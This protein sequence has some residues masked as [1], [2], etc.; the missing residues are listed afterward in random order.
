M[1]G[2]SPEVS[3]QRRAGRVEKCVRMVRSR[4]VA[5]IAANRYTAW[6][7]SSFARLFDPL[8]LAIL[9]TLGALLV[10]KRRRLSIRLLI[11]PVALLLAFT[12]IR[13]APSGTFT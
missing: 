6:P 13:R 10:W 7:A 2:R 11:V 12:S 3:E 1:G 4:R 5:A 8:V 9:M